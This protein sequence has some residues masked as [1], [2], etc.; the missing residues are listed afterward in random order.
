MNDLLP[1]RELVLIGAGHTNSHI[2]RMWRMHAIPDVRLTV[3]SPFSRATYSGMLPGTLAGLY[4]QD[5]MEIDLVRLCASVGARLITAEVT[6]FDPKRRRI[7]FDDRPEMRYDVASIG[8]GSVPSGREIWSRHDAVLSIKPMATFLSRLNARLDSLNGQTPVRVHVVGAGAAGTEVSLCIEALLQKRGTP[9]RVEI[10]DAGD[11]VLSGYADAVVDKVERELGRREIRVRANTRVA[12]YEDGHLLL[13]G[14][15]RLAT[16]LVLWATRAAPPP[17]LENFRLPKADDGFLAVKP[18]LRTTADHPVFVVGDTATIVDQ[19]VPKAGVYAVREGPVLWDNVQRL[20]RGDELVPYEPQESFLSLLALGD[21]RAAGQFHARSLLGRWVWHWKD[22]IDQR[23]MNKHR[24]YEPMTQ[25]MMEQRAREQEKLLDGPG[26]A[27]EPPA[28]RCR[29][30]GGKIATSVLAS[31]LDRLDIPPSRFTRQG[32]D[33]PDDAALLTPDAGMD[34][35]S[36][37]FFHAFHDDP[38]LVGRV[39]ALN[40]L[41][42]IFA[43]GAD[44]AGALAM[45]TLPEGRDN[46]QA[47]LLYQLLAGGLREIEAAGATLLGG[48]TTESADLTIGYTA[49]GRLD[50]REPFTKG[51]LQP[52]DRLIL[53]KP[54]GTATLLAG[55]PLCLTTHAWMDALLEWMLQS[56]RE[57]ALVAREVGVTGVTD[58]TGFGLAGHLLEM[59]EASGVDARI[60]LDALPL[61]A[62]FE[63]LS[64][65]GVRSSLDEG[66]RR[67]EAHVDV[68]H[69][70]QRKRPA[71]HALFD[72][73]TSGGLVIAVR[74]EKA[75][76]L[77]ER[78]RDVSAL[79]T[80]IGEV[81]E[82]SAE[83]VIRI[84]SSPNAAPPSH[85]S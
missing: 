80:V 36:V 6:G 63:S 23:F 75:D 48:H 85:D 28:M 72:P 69:P 40:S 78:L 52:G 24:E 10:L 70:D 38:Y 50:G 3:I 81:G 33:A 53:T 84:V 32:L 5:D 13:E 79:G 57:P 27:S 42:D 20:F 2:I 67:A 61:H 18:T 56:N 73:Q 64:R 11:R 35:I 4:T 30:C 37:D 82:R 66:N 54:L 19:P 34:V 41:S 68:E 21:G 12:G 46:Q 76:T 16:D 29:G 15:E 22:W 47:E 65:R 26:R 45:V 8:I 25:A 77:A 62:G 83:A 31:A 17:V 74:P 59:L 39:A 43:M 44:A 7:L 58:V 1:G 49:L 9:N 14:G 51:G 55:H 71:Y 60:D